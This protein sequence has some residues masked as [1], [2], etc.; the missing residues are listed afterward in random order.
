MT[1][2]CSSAATLPLVR[3]VV[4][5]GPGR[6]ALGPVLRLSGLDRRAY[7]PAAQ[8]VL[9][10]TPLQVVRILVVL[11]LGLLLAAAPTLVLTVAA[12]Q[13]IGPVSFTG[14]MLLLPAALSGGGLLLTLALLPAL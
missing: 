6:A 8:P 11:A 4:P 14:G 12:G 7:P 1:A 13:M 5:D 2:M 3:P 10:L 9:D